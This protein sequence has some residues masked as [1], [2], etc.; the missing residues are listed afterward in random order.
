MAK[1][2][3][4][5]QELII[6]LDADSFDE[7]TS[8]SVGQASSAPD[9]LLLRCGCHFHWQCLL[10]ESPQIALDLA[11]PACQ[12]SIVSTA[13]ASSATNQVTHTASEPR[14]ITKYHNEGG[15]QENLDILPLITEEAYLDAHP[16]A[17][18]AIAFHTMCGEGDVTGIVELLNALEEDPDEEDMLAKDLLRFQN[19]LDGGKS[20]LHVALERS[21]QESVWLLLWLASLLPTEQFP[22]EVLKAAE[23]MGAGRSTAEG[24]DIRSLK[25]E[26]GL[27]AEQYAER[28]GNTWADLR[29]V[30]G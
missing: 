3:L 27:S 21:Q 13:A 30:L 15:I 28:M 5:S 11:C 7:A 26:N 6:E 24:V 25:D 14:I 1:C 20:G 16:A 12:N 23:T 18:P 9:D 22:E 19:P 29:G 2:R 10:D 17:R 8:S 4:C